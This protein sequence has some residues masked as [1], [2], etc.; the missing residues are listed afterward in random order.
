MATGKKDMS[1]T[2]TTCIIRLIYTRKILN[3]CYI[4]NNNNATYQIY[5]RV[6]ASF[7][8]SRFR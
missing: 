1:A 3:I 6:G 2:S 5:K 7:S 4:N 8:F